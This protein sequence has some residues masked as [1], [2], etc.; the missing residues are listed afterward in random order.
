MS[1]SEK[2]FKEIIFDEK[3]TILKSELDG[4]DT[5]NRTGKSL[6]M[7]SIPYA[8]GAELEK[9]TKNWKK[10]SIVTWLEFSYM[11]DDY[12][13]F[14]DG[15]KFMVYKNNMMFNAA[16]SIGE[17]RDV[18]SELFGFS[19]KLELSNR[20]G[21]STIYPGG[22][23]LPFYID[24]DKGW[25]G[26]KQSFADVKFIKDWRKNI[27]YFYTGRRTERYYEI[28]KLRSEPTKKRE[29]LKH[30]K[31]VLDK[32]IDEE[33]FKNIESLKVNFD[34]KEFEEETK[35]LSNLLNKNLK[36]KELIREK[37]L[38]L[39]NKQ[40][41]INQE[42]ENAKIGLAE[43]RKDIDYLNSEIR[44]EVILC[45]LC[46]TRHEN[47]I[48]NRFLVYKEEKECIKIIDKCINEESK[49]ALE[50]ENVKFELE[51]ISAEV[52]EIQD[53]M[54]RKKE[55]ITF[56]EVAKAEGVKHLIKELKDNLEYVEEN[57]SGL[58]GEIKKYTNEMTQI[59]K[60]SKS[61]EE[62]FQATFKEYIKTLN[63][64]DFEEEEIHKL[65]DKI[66]S[67]GSDTARAILA[68]YLAIYKV[69][70]GNQAM[71]LFPIIIDSPRQQ[72]QGTLNSSAI[73]DFLLAD[74]T[75]NENYQMIIATTEIDSKYQKDAKVY[76]FV[77]VKSLLKKEGYEETFREYQ[78]NIAHF[79]AW[80]F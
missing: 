34:L 25:D 23:L 15:E 9:Y 38:K 11:N 37:L 22:M 72:E 32:L 42:Y 45:P 13:I 64:V 50:L 57:I 5:T 6:I 20:S 4:G 39:H 47:D 29:K 78:N 75:E 31:A 71:P 61:I 53:I 46:G 60:K 68:D 30:E 69:I 26:E 55:N 73:F 67:G 1:K 18:Y 19:I 76:N 33:E 74:D 16:K 43:L 44:T 52:K 7:K 49:I 58:D 48:E 21:T 28:L 2:T 51:D 59:T 17:L 54:A 63:V 80:T 14:R 35:E 3:L 24:Q 12:L 10:L 66:S 56:E 27:L 77:E 79:S 62:K 41:E 40:F 65:G 36:Q 70:E 8:F